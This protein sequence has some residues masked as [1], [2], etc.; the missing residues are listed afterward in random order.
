MQTQ[1]YTKDSHRSADI[2][3]VVVA[4][5]HCARPASEKKVT[6][7]RGGPPR[8]ATARHEIEEQR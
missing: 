5:M 8:D 7:E 3:Q 2:E 1:A 4:C 6:A